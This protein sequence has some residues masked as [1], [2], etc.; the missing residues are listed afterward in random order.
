MTSECI[1]IEVKKKKNSQEHLTQKMA[2]GTLVDICVLRSSFN[3]HKEPLTFIS[4]L[5][6]KTHYGQK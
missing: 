4:L 5:L 1:S 2:H 6:K 3:T